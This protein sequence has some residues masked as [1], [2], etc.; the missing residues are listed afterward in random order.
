MNRKQRQRDEWEAKA[1]RFLRLRA[2]ATALDIGA[3][4]VRGEPRAAKISMSAREAIG[5]SIAVGLARRGVVT[6]ER[7]N[8]FKARN[9]RV[10]PRQ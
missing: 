9:A 5:L 8:T 4:A 7:D 6:V 10:Q 3:A 2:R 1:L